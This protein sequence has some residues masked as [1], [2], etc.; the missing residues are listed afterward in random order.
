MKKRHPKGFYD[1]SITRIVPL[2][3][4]I[5]S[6][7]TNERFSAFISCIQ[8]ASTYESC[9]THNDLK[10]LLNFGQIIEPIYYGK[11]GA[12]SDGRTI[13]P[14][15]KS[16][17]MP[18]STHLRWLIN[19]GG[20]DP[21]IRVPTSKDGQNRIDLFADKKGGC[22]RQ[23]ALSL[24]EEWLDAPHKKANP[25]FRFEAPT[26]PDVYIETKEYILI[27]EGKRTENKLTTHTSWMDYDR[28]Q[29][30]RHMDSLCDL[31]TGIHKDNGKPVFGLYLI[32][33]I[34]DPVIKDH[35]VPYYDYATACKRYS[36]LEYWKRSL[37]HRIEKYEKSIEI[38]QKHFLGTLTWEAIE[39]F[40]GALSDLR[41]PRNKD[42]MTSTSK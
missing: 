35:E 18:Q 27:I 41:F 33:S 31:S 16:G 1:S 32:P 11:Q 7:N 10:S 2:F 30:I 17:L 29:L 8:G 25:W 38:M 15:E 20:L 37:P 22:K 4:F 5:R 12:L 6:A 23:N 3:N 24:L 42:E 9:A 13:E 34:N 14:G 26:K 39:T 40:G 28:D 21:R 36:S 19:E